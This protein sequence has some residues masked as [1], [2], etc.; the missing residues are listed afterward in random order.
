MNNNEYNIYMEQQIP[1]PNQDYKVLVRCYTFNH[2][3]YI[4]D[5]LK[6]FAM[7]ETSFPFV[8]VVVDDC[9]K[10]GEQMAIKSFLQRECY[11]EKVSCYNDDSFDFVYAR[12]RTNA[13]CYFAIYLLRQNHYSIKK[14]KVQYVS[15]WR[16]HCTYEA[17]CEGDDYWTDCRKLQMQVDFLESNQDYSACAHQSEII[18]DGDGVFWENVPDP[19]SLKDL[20][21]VSR[22]FHTA[23]IVY[24]IKPFWAMSTPKQ[25]VVSGDKLMILR[26]ASLGPIKF[27]NRVMCVYR[28]HNQGMSSIVPIKRLKQDTYIAEYMT[29]VCPTFPKYRYLSFLYGTFATYTK[30]VSKPMKMWYLFISFLL[31]FSYFPD[32]VKVLYNKVKRR[33]EK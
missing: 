31:S 16:G 12:H 10:D 20:T 8:C 24:R 5:A 21:I 3:N 2:S 28:K 4:E 1:I 6:G 32:N 26:L 11:M 29:M 7:Q 33:Y 23:S 27:L 19:I 9:S 25:T 14:S 15:P 17:L 30:D 18:G 22:L 13:N